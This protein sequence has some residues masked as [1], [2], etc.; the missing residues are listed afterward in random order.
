MLDARSFP[1]AHDGGLGPVRADLAK[2]RRIRGVPGDGPRHLSDRPVHQ[3]L[4]AVDG[5]DV[6]SLSEEKSGD[7]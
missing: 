6:V 7:P 4:I 5:D 1:G 3:T 2:E